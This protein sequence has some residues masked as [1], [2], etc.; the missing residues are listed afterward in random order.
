MFYKFE[1]SDIE[2]YADETIPYACASDI[3]TANSLHDL[4]TIT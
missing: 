1:D 2:I 4:T 3:N